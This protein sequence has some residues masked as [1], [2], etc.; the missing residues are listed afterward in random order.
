MNKNCFIGL[1]IIVGVILFFA[2]A[3]NGVNNSAITHEEQV[4]E[5]KSAIELQ[6]K[7]RVDLVYNLVDC[8]EQY[9]NYENN[10]LKEISELR[11][12]ATKVDSSQLT[13][14]LNSV[15]E[16]Y[17]ELKA[18]DNYKNLML[19]LET[20]ENLIV[21]YRENYNKQVRSYNSFVRKF[22]NK[23]VLSIMGYEVIDYSYLEYNA[24][25]TAPQRLFDRK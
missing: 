1:G 6:E 14:V 22:P 10:T 18:N 21:Q 25:E 16:S 17:P 5:S 9:A 15:T 4:A 11:A 8:V 23:Q 19:E 2:F 24:P 7:R 20:T 3:F 12:S 13:T